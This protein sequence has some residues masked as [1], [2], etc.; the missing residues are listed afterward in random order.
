MWMF[1]YFPKE[2][3]IPIYRKP[4]IMELNGLKC[5]IGH[6]DGL[7][8]GDKG[9]KILK[10]FFE[11]KTCQWLFARLHPN[12]GLGMAHHFSKKSRIANGNYNEE[13]KNEEKEILINYCK[14]FIKKE[15]I[16][17]FVFGHRHIP[18][19]I[20]LNE[21]SSY[22]NTGEWVNYFSY[23]RMDGNKFELK[24]FK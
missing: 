19:E 13:M 1:D 4:E 20:K 15:H 3:N 18:I 5:M 10:T 22:V 21:S 9:Y 6:G 23:F 12:F 14:N 24:S 7:G 16:D 11:S 17:L 2:L 8:S